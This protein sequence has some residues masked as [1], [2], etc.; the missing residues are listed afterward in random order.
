MFREIRKR[1]TYWNALTLF[2][3]LILFIAVLCGVVKWSLKTSGET[4]LKNVADALISDSQSVKTDG[5]FD[6]SVHEQLGYE[7]LEWNAN[8]SIR[9]QQVASQNMIEEGYQILNAYG[10]DDSFYLTQS[11]GDDEYR[12]YQTD[13]DHN[14]K[15]I[16]L[17]VFQ[18]ITTENSLVTFVLQYLL[19]IGGIGL[20]VLVPLSYFLAGRSLRPIKENYEL[21]K[22]FIAD[23]SHELRTP[24]TVIQTNVEVLQMKEDQT[25]RENEK[26]LQAIDDE[27]E[28]MANL[29]SELLNNAQNDAQLHREE[30]LEDIRFSLSD[31]CEQ[32]LSRLKPLARD[33]D[34]HL[35]SKV[36]P[37]IEMS[38]DEKKVSQ[39]LRIFLDNAMKYTP[40]GGRIELILTENKRNFIMEIKDNGLGIPYE[41][42]K[43]IFSR[44]YR[45]DDARSRAT[46]GSGLGLSIADSIV[47]GMGGKIKLDSEPGKGSNFSIYLPKKNTK[48]KSV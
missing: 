19:I 24:I 47:Q 31:T 12:I 18:N 20:L 10:D 42:Q 23:A 32:A 13:F 17:Q 33:M 3:F 35:I 36:T 38:G 44:F 7:Y 16:T 6:T 1:I 9:S 22:T 27:C 43:K 5:L 8:Q 46:G 4:Y 28:T 15:T 40:A 26:W 25:I 37:G 14:G 2:A 41:D 45:V 11:I 34:L 30:T 21:Q 29:I 48:S 39:L